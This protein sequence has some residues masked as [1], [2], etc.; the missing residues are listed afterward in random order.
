MGKK[1]VRV[2]VVAIFFSQQLFLKNLDEGGG[3]GNP[4]LFFSEKM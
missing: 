2:G 3:S 1:Q 4:H